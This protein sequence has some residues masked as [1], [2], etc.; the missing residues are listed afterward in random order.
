MKIQNNKSDY[1]SKSGE[2]RAVFVWLGV[3]TLSP[4]MISKRQLIKNMKIFCTFFF[5][6]VKYEFT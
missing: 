4:E 2:D 1:G 6:S 5:A 3:K